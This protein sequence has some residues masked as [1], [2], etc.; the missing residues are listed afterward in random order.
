MSGPI[1]CWTNA[2]SEF[3]GVWRNLIIYIME[4]YIYGA[5]IF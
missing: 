3:V 4:I 5:Y 1:H 2:D